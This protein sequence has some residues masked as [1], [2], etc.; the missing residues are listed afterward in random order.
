MNTGII[1]NSDLFFPLAHFLKLHNNEVSIFYCSSKEEFINQKVEGFVGQMQLSITTEKN[2]AKDLYK[3][4]NEKEFAVCFIIGYSRLIDI[5]K[6]NHLSAKIFNIH[7][8]LLPLFKGPAPVFWQLKKGSE[9]IGLS[10]HS[11]SSEF[12]SGPIVW[13]KEITNEPYYNYRIT[14]QIFS[15]H[16]IE[17]VVYILHL[18][19]NQLPFPVIKTELLNE[20]QKKPTLSD[21]LINWNSMSAKEICDLIKACSPWNKGAATFFNGQ[22]LKL[23][24]ARI[25]KTEPQNIN[26][27][28]GSI[29]EDNDGFI[30]YSLNNEAIKVNMIYY[31]ECFVP[32]Y[33]C[34]IYGLVKGKRLG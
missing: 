26:Q 1:T 16:C 20:Y 21:V 2:K 28:S 30:I 13:Q 32:S 19:T 14:S 5:S 23:M 18:L 17:G 24:D 27:I 29:A 6:L 3:W 34:K 25:I 7:F 12:D 31:N 8:G 33:Q 9:K 15:Q 10:I 11:I 22:E 4:L